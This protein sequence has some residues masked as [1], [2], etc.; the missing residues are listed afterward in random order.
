MLTHFAF[1]HKTVRQK[2]MTT[3]NVEVTAQRLAYGIEDAA[4]VLGI[5]RT[6]L[7]ELMKAETG[8]EVSNSAGGD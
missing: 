8:L 4:A 1:N 6:K 7:L 3:Q 2:G 5:G